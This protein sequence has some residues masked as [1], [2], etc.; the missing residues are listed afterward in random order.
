MTTST[1]SPDST[2]SAAEHETLPTVGIIGLGAMG[3][4]MAAWLAESGEPV[5]AMDNDPTARAHVAA[6]VKVHDDLAAIAIECPVLILSLP[7]PT[8]IQQVVN[9]VLTFDEHVQPTIIIDTSTSDPEVSVDLA[10]RCKQKRIAYLDAP[11]SGGQSGARTGTLTAFVGA[12]DAAIECARPVLDAITG[13]RWH[14]MGLVGTGHATKLVN[15]MLCAAHLVTA[16]EAVAIARKC[17]VDPHRLIKA[18]NQGSGRSAVTENNYPRWVLSDNFDSGF[19][20]RLM[21]RD[22]HLFLDVA[23]RAG[24]TPQVLAA[25]GRAWAAAAVDLS[26]DDDFNRVVQTVHP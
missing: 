4:A 20:F 22:T 8:Q 24:M 5:Q 13:G 9:Q 6:G 11:I 2:N 21:A 1:E 26:P 10:A 12:S 16:A 15:N 19:Q 3:G 23:A 25:A 17:G 18:L 7:G 14:H